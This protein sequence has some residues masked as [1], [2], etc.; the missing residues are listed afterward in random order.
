MH[1]FT[2]AVGWLLVSA[3]VVASA[4]SESKNEFAVTVGRTFVADQTIPNANTVNNVVHSGKGTTLDFT[5]GRCLIARKPL[6]FAIELPVM[7][8]PDVDMNFGL[9]QVPS[10]YSSIF[11]TPAAHISLWRDSLF[12]PWGSFGGGFGHFEASSD[13]VF[14]GDNPGHRVKN[15]GALHWGVGLDIALPWKRFRSFAGRFELRDNWTAVA[16]LNVTSGQTR[17][18]NLYFGGGLVFRF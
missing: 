15:T 6:S 1:R 9:N 14:G 12:S 17:Q 8:N 7:Y 10:Q 16:P 11:I 3:S 2:V 4:Q 13:L 5:Y 18:N